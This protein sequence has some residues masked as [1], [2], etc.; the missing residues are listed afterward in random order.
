MSHQVTIGPELA[1]MNWVLVDSSNYKVGCAQQHSIIKC[2]WFLG[3]WI[4]A[5]PEGTSQFL[6][7]AA[8]MPTFALPACTSGLM[9]HH[10]LLSVSGERL[11]PGLQM[12]LHQ[13]QAP[14]KSGQLQHVRPF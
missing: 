2:E 12:G 7:A 3:D 13:T 10:P 4:S 9:G 5:G 14:P 1:I 11:G 6:K 8:Q